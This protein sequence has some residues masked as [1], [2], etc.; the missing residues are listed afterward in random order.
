MSVI[1]KKGENMDQ[2]GFDNVEKNLLDNECHHKKKGECG[3]C[4]F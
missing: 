4:L 3:S 2:A 1:M